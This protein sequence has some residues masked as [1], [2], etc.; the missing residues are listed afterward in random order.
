MSEMSCPHCKNPIYD[1]N[2]LL[3]HFC[4][5]SLSRTSGGVLGAMR[6]AGMKWVLITVAGM[7]VL[8]FILISMR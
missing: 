6:G 7:I 5:N 1:E 3:C 4:G 2:A 8:S